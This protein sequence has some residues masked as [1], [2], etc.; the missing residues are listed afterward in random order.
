MLPLALAPT[1]RGMR[2]N[3]ATMDAKWWWL[4]GIIGPAGAL[5]VVREIVTSYR[6]WRA[7]RELQLS[8]A[9]R[10]EVEALEDEFREFIPAIFGLE[11][12]DCFISNDSSLSDF[13]LDEEQLAQLAEQIRSVYG[14]DV[15]LLPDDRL[16]TIVAAIALRR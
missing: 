12:D 8:Y 2:Q 13:A 6:E 3:L 5:A 4:L 7:S 9:P 14:V 16:V 11:Y 1:A 15:T 10:D